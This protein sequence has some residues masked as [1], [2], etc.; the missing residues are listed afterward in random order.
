MPEAVPEAETGDVSATET[1]SGLEPETGSEV[2]NP[3][4]TTLRLRERQPTITPSIQTHRRERRHRRRLIELQRLLQ[5][6]QSLICAQTLTKVGLMTTAAYGG[7][8]TT[9]RKVIGSN[10]LFNPVL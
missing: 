7:H 3:R 6:S 9:E 2:A 4:M 5:P 10:S 1:S 8:R